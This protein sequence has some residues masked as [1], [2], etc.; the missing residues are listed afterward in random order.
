MDE[1]L[2]LIIFATFLVSLIGFVGVVAL[3]ISDRMLK[4]ILLCLIGL[5][6]GA[7]MGGAFLHLLAESVTVSDPE[8][9]F[10]ITL[11]GYV[12]F[13]VLEKVMWRHCHEKDC[14][15]HTFAYLNLVGDGVHNF[16]DGLIIA[17]SFIV[18]VPLG[19]VTTLAVAIHELPQ[20]IGDFGVLVY[21]GFGKR[22]AL[23]LNFVTALTAIAGGIVGFFLSQ[24]IGDTTKFL[25]PFAAGGFIYIAASDL[26]PELHKETDIWRSLTVFGFFL[27]GIFL[28][29]AVKIVFGG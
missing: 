3:A 12:L 13:F 15:I 29:L 7:L 11:L 2:L 26:V 17:S 6:A 22:K 10:L 5:S 28:M 27:L 25:L 9:V 24:Y 4:K 18:S 20:E 19:F 1:T 8:T 16:I 14:K 21:G 23:V